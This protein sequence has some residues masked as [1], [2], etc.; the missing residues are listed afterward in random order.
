MFHAVSAQNIIAIFRNGDRSS[1]GAKVDD[2]PRITSTLLLSVR[3][4]GCCRAALSHA[5]TASLARSLTYMQLGGLDVSDKRKPPNSNP[6]PNYNSDPGLTP[7]E[8][9]VMFDVSGFR[10]DGTSVWRAAPAD[11]SRMRGARCGLTWMWHDIRTTQ[12]ISERK[13]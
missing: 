2:A 5:S 8:R 12:R 4:L 1:C 9:Q 3:T 11:M 7:R 6:C 10:Y 13:F